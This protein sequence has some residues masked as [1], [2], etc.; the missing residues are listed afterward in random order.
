MKHM[1]YALL[2]LQQLHVISFYVHLEVFISCSQGRII[3]KV[4]MHV[5]QMP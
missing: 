1:H 5:L 2:K 3:F 4:L